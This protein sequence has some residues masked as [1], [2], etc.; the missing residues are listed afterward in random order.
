MKIQVRVTPRAR[1]SSVAPGSAGT[2]KVKVTEPAIGG[3]A[4]AA[5]IQLLAKHYNVPKRGVR[6]LKGETGRQKLVE[7]LGRG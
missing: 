3:R 7:I 5:V 1:E 6:I 2:L 4:N